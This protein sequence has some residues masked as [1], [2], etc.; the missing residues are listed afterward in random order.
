MRCISSELQLTPD[1]ASL[2]PIRL[3]VV[4]SALEGQL[5]GGLEGASESNPSGS[6]PF[7]G[8]VYGLPR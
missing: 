3:S 5:L 6:K 7:V 1:A 2:S 8:T 4:S